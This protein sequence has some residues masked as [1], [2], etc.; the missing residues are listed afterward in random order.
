[1]AAGILL[2]DFYGRLYH[3][4]QNIGAL[5]PIYK[6]TLHSGQT[7]TG[8]DQRDLEGLSAD[9][10]AVGFVVFQRKMVGYATEPKP[11]SVLERAV[12]SIEPFD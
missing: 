10:C 5:M 4:A 7:F 6:F 1:M 12:A 3:C 11:I 8:E 2:D 9:L